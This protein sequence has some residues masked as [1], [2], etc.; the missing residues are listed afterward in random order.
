MTGIECHTFTAQTATNGRFIMLFTI[1]WIF[2]FRKGWFRARFGACFMV[3]RCLPGGNKNII[4]GLRNYVPVAVD[5]AGF[6][7]HIM[8]GFQG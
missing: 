8:P 1:V 2:A 3:I 4:S 6:Y 7:L 5:I